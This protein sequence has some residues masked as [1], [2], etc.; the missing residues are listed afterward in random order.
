M[1]ELPEVET[2]RQ[3]L[4]EQM[5]GRQVSS[6]P[7]IDPRMIKLGGYSG[8][9]LT[10]RLVGDHL[11]G[12]DRRGK[13]L[14]FRWQRP[15]YLIVHLGMSGRLTVE[16]ATETRASHTHVIIRFDGW[17]LRLRDPR[18]F[19]R[20]GWLD[21]LDRLESRLGL[22]PLSSGFTA[23][24]LGQKLQG[25]SAPI[26]SLLLNQAIVAGLGNIYVDEALHLSG[27]HPAQSAD[28]IDPQSVTRLVR[29]I[30]RVLRQSLKNRGTSF[31]DYVDAL[32]QP[33]R[34]Q[35]HLQ[36]YGRRGLA[37]F[38][39]G[40]TIATVVIQGRTSHFCVRCQPPGAR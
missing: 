15:G 22:E 24:H 13:Y 32:G 30:R 17:D 23:K 29:N 12:V 9:G 37:C 5:V 38:R 26:K 1:P 40:S 19:G 16:S 6:V 31:S 4:A 27:I 7:H 20:V 8:D 18:R 33:G 2:I 28:A 25:R 39:C 21:D 10:T 3:Y 14:I 34:N 11:A 35:G 36:V